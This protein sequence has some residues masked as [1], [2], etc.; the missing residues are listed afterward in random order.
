MRLRIKRIRFRKQHVE[1][2]IAELQKEAVFIKGR[3]QLKRLFDLGLDL[4]LVI[5]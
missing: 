1:K 4:P 2:T 3:E 5:K